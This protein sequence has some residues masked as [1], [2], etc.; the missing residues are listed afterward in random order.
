MCDEK[1]TFFLIIIIATGK[2][3]VDTNGLVSL[4]CMCECVI[5]TERI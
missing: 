4:V 5:L 3:D 1:Y 2:P